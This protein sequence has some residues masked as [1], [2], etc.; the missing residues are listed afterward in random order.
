MLADDEIKS[1]E[2]EKSML[3]DLSNNLAKVRNKNDLRQITDEKLK[4]L[5][6]VNNISFCYVSPD[7]KTFGAFILDPMS[8]SVR[9]PQYG[10]ITSIMH[11]VN[12]GIINKVLA[13]EDP[14]VYDMEAYIKTN[15]KVPDY[16]RMIYDVGMRQMI[17]SRL[18]NGKNTIGYLAI[19][20][21]VK[22][23]IDINQ[24]NLIK[25]I[26]AQLS[27]ALANIKANEQ[28]EDQVQE[29]K[30]YK[31][32]L[33]E[34]NSYLQEEINSSFNHRDIIGVSGEMKKVF[35]M[36]TQVASSDSTVLLL[37]ETGT[38]KELI[39][40]AI[41]NTSPRKNNLMVKI[42]CAAL[43]ANLIESELFGHERGSF[44][45]ATERRIGKFE[46]ANN[47]TLFLDEIGE[48]PMDL[49]AKLLRAL[50]EKEIERIGGKTTINLDVRIIAATNRDLEK[51]MEEGKF[52]SDLFYR[53]N[54]FPI[55][56]PPLRNRRDDIP[57]LA[58]HF[59]EKFSKKMGKQVSSLSNKVL[60]DLMQYNWPGNIRELEHLLERSILLTQGE[61]IKEI[62][63]PTQ[64][65][66][67]IN[68]NDN[69]ELELKT[70]DQNEREYILKVIKYTKGKIAGSGGAAELLGIPPSTL[71]SKM[72][73]LGI[74]KEHIG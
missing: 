25:A 27:V 24:L 45:G 36:V 54:I 67:S 10:D 57:S 42:N 30:K 72:Q 19:T 26:A 15:N 50:Q 1:R 66:N 53:L 18:K 70:I 65:S 64:K 34:E 14:L 47:G 63:L 59:V 6:V 43:P 69:E 16:F 17:F 9:H 21:K 68:K 31:N 41:H 28:I 51:L 12:D 37:G 48:I 2:K 33:E 29:I 62:M 39:A 46:L 23:H 40:R 35:H 56:L 71:T 58:L 32:Q 44:T 74:R 52:R 22:T 13:S 60:N 3:L 20:K 61:M 7:G 4:T 55:D 11:P 49:Q 73:R 5:L 38:G 8:P